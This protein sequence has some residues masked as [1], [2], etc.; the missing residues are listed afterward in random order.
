MKAASASRPRAPPEEHSGGRE[1]PGR[2][3]QERKR[4]EAAPF[5]RFPFDEHVP[6]D[7]N[8]EPGASP[9]EASGHPRHRGEPDG[10]RARSVDGPSPVANRLCRG[11]AKQGTGQM[12]GRERETVSRSRPGDDNPRGGWTHVRERLRRRQ[13]DPR[14]TA[15]RDRTRLAYT[16]R[17]LR[18][19]TLHPEAAGGEE[20]QEGIGRTRGSGREAIPVPS[21]SIIHTTLR[22]S[23]A[24]WHSDSTARN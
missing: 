6:S 19:E 22:R 12:P 10:G 23:I 17:R 7:P 24:P 16:I 5:V 4:P 1:H 13:P 3:P 2:Q 21:T 9:D 8:P 14:R 20:F 11:R 18:S 15:R